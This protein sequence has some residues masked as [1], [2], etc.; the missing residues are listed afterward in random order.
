M[1]A[2]R[3]SG[4]PQPSQQIDAALRPHPQT[5]L[6]KPEQGKEAS[7][8]K[9][10]IIQESNSTP[11]LRRGAEPQVGINRITPLA[12]NIIMAVD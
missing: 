12:L 10:A 1:S 7:A 3:Q 6:P 2:E 4:Q 5:K 9:E 8:K 11:N